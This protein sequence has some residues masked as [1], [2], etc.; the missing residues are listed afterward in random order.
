[1]RHLLW[2]A[3]VVFARVVELLDSSQ[4][5][6]GERLVAGADRVVELALHVLAALPDWDTTLSR[7]P[8]HVGPHFHVCLQLSG[9]GGGVATRSP[10]RS[11]RRPGARLASDVE[12]F[13][14]ATG[15]L[16]VCLSTLPRRARGT[17]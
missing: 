10:T 13:G 7:L 11:P 16:R 5:L 3:P 15:S 8:F 14:R 1:M 12:R 9:R 6:R 2:T 4:E 17:T